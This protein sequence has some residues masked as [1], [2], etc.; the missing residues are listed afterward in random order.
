MTG[1]HKSKRKLEIGKSCNPKF[2]TNYAVLE[3]LWH[4]LLTC[5]LSLYGFQCSRLLHFPCQ[6]TANL[7]PSR[8]NIYNML[9]FFLFFLLKI[10]RISL[11]YPQNVPIGFVYLRWIDT[12]II[13]TNLK[14]L[15]FSLL[16]KIHVSLH[17]HNNDRIEID[18][19]HCIQ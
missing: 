3:D 17:Y 6:W 19:I 14:T 9:N 12:H 16:E 13:I 15:T 8:C 10:K 18:F 11:R 5:A 7:L 2:S 1:I 4:S